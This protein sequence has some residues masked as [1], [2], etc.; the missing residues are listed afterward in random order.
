MVIILIFRYFCTLLFD[1]QKTKTF[2][3][4]KYDK[5]DN[6]KRKSSILYRLFNRR[7]HGD[8]ILDN[9]IANGARKAF[10]STQSTIMN[11]NDI[12]CLSLVLI[13]LSI[14]FVRITCGEESLAT[15]FPSVTSSLSSAISI[16][17][18]STIAVLNCT[19][20]NVWKGDDCFKSEPCI[21]CNESIQCSKESTV[22]KDNVCLDINWDS[23]ILKL[24]QHVLAENLQ[25]PSNAIKDKK[26]RQS[27]LS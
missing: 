12:C 11:T 21:F 8:L 24:S 17:N 26:I 23:K 9:N 1:K 6:S 15:E 7:R 3:R 13:W 4:T 5:T 18:T 2:Q 22:C 14:N 25:N 19:R 16:E 27:L 10:K 20:C